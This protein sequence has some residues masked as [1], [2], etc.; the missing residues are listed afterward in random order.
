M[1][2]DNWWLT[3]SVLISG[4][5]LAIDEDSIVKVLDGGVLNEALVILS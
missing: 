4:V 3:L 1:L 5:S 2:I